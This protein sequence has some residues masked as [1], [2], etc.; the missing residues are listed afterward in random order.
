MGKRSSSSNGTVAPIAPVA[1]MAR[2]R[3]TAGWQAE[4]EQWQL[5]PRATPIR[6]KRG[7]DGAAAG[8]AHPLSPLQPP[9]P[10]QPIHRAAR[11]KA[12]IF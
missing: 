11:E 1:P 4:K 7:A 9:A 5:L 2:R 12:R 6:G 3:A 10:A 8:G